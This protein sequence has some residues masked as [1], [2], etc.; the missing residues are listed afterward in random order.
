MEETKMRYETPVVEDLGD[1]VELTAANTAGTYTDAS[2]P[3]NTPITSLT[4][5]I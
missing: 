5:S 4:F 3:A 2:F 1:L